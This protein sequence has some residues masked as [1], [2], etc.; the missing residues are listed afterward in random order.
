MKGRVGSILILSLIMNHLAHAAPADSAGINCPPGT[1]KVEVTESLSYRPFKNTPVRLRPHIVSRKLPVTPYPMEIL[2]PFFKD[3]LIF[4]TERDLLCAPQVMGLDRQRSTAG[5]GDY[6]YVR[7]IENVTERKY[8][9][10]R[11]GRK[12][13]HPITREYLGYE[14]ALVGSADLTYLGDVSEMLVTEASEGITV[15]NRVL[16]GNILPP[17]ETLY[18]SPA[19]TTTEGFI[20][21]IKDGVDYAG[22]NQVVLISLGMRDGIEPG[23]TVAIYQTCRKGRICNKCPCPGQLPDWRVGYALVF[24]TYEKLSLALIMESVEHIRLLDR[25]R[26]P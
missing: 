22:K 6:L 13:F 14:G 2:K 25:V 23:N 26:S 1:R 11:A 12:Y 10:F 18:P 9:V 15:G 24:R 7:G 21:S 3:A 17:Y 5:K 16:P 19:T 8:K 20:L 4:C